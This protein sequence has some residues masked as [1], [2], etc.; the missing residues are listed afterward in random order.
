MQ[1]FTAYLMDGRGQPAD[2]RRSTT[3]VPVA[4]HDDLHD[5]A[6][7]EPVLDAEWSEGGS[8]SPRRPTRAV[9]RGLGRP[10]RRLHGVAA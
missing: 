8:P 6:V 5:D 9:R 2:G 7:E 3:P 1:F 4:L 10:L